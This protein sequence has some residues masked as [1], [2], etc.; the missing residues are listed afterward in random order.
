MI[1]NSRPEYVFIRVCIVGLQAIAPLAVLYTVFELLFLPA[2]SRLPTALRIWLRV[3]AIFYLFLSIPYRSYLQRDATHPPLKSKQ[4]RQELFSRVVNNTEREQLE[5]HVCFWFKGAKFDEIG[6]EDIKSWVSWAFFE[7]RT[8]HL[9]DEELEEYVR[10]LEG[11]LGRT[12]QDGKGKAVP[13]RLT[14]DP[15]EMQHRSLLWYLVRI[16]NPNTIAPPVLIP[17]RKMVGIV[18][19]ITYVRMWFYGYQFYRQSLSDFL[20]LFP[21][22]PIALT[23]RHRSPA[24]HLTYWLRPH[25]SKKRLPIVFIHGI[26]IGLYP[27]VDFLHDLQSQDHQDGQVGILALEL[28]PI[29]FRITHPMPSKDNLCAEILQILRY[30]NITS[31]VLATH[32]YGSVITTHMLSNPTLQPKI[33]SILLIDPV[34]FLLHTPDVAYNFTTRKPK[35]ANEWQLWYFASKDPGVAHTLGRHF[36][37]AQNALW[38]EEELVPLVRQGLRVTVILSG[39]DLIVDAEAV[40]RHLASGASKA[41][42]GTMSDDRSDGWKNEPWQ[43]EGLELLWFEDTDHAQVF[44]SKTKRKRLLHVVARYCTGK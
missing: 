17:V 7:G 36:H 1:N 15:I 23:A 19:L 35:E 44:D 33:S 11:M 10:G 22:R 5:R 6:R 25:T 39:R 27:Y 30:H 24:K 37:W 38:L 41:G 14:L 28:M 32:S 43:G 40:G 18:D 31:F 16:I 20:T 4:D 9:D 3:E 42:R 12:F 34:T 8:E 26:G 21:F 2:P 29:C 13:L